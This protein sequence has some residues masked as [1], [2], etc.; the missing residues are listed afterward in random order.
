MRAPP[1][2]IVL[3]REESQSRAWR[4][5]LAAAGATVLELPLLRYAALTPPAGVDPAAFDWILFTSPQGVHAFADT[6]LSPGGARIGALGGGTAAVLADHGWRD[7]LNARCRDGAELA[8]AFV[9][10]GAAPAR[11]L[12]PGPDRRLSEPAAGL[13]AAG[14]TVVEWPLYRTEAIPAGELPRDPFAEGDLVFFASPSA[15]GAF[16]EAYALRPPCVAIGETTAAAAR[17]VGFDP[18]VADAPDLSAMARACGLG[19]VT[20]PS[21]REMPS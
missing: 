20:D 13:R 15:V 1:R 14:C 3:T 2:R 16:A 7:G 5:A 21:F 19:S 9:A 12:L 17:A 10:A 11:V 8:R 18:L 4:E 6:G